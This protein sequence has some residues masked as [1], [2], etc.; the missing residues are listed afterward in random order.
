MLLDTHLLL[1]SVIDP[2]RFSESYR[3]AVEDAR[4][5]VYFSIVSVW[6]IAIKFKLGRADFGVRP[7]RI[8]AAA[9][10]ADFAQLDVSVEACLLLAELPL[11]HRDPFD[12]MLVAQAMTAP[13][14]LL[15]VDRQLAAYSEL[16]R[17]LA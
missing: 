2:G 15:T 14:F 8:V 9:H 6:E 4:T 3:A 13:M 7:E 1:W 17:L 5:P 12:R 16:V 11:H 10:N